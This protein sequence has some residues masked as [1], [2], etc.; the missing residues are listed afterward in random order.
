MLGYGEMKDVLA[1]EMRAG[2]CDGSEE[3]M[4]T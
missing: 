2:C 3:G 1:L 4:M